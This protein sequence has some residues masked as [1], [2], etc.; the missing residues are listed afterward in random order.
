MYQFL[1]KE[2]SFFSPKDSVSAS[3]NPNIMQVVKDAILDDDN[4]AA[5]IA[6]AF[7]RLSHI[8]SFIKYTSFKL[9]YTL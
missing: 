1:Y 9:I 7:N 6:E 8:F 3:V 5:T 4:I 2:V